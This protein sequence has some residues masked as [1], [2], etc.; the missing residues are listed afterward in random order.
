MQVSPGNVWSSRKPQN[1]IREGF[2]PSAETI[3]RGETELLWKIHVGALGK[4]RLLLP[5][6]GHWAECTENVAGALE[7]N[8][9]QGRSL[10]TPRHI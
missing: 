9:L 8:L 2:V 6:Q 1:S 7:L 10:A 3:C 4:E 5:C